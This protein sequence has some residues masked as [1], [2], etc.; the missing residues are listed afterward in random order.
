MSD[1]LAA[2]APAYT[3]CAYCPK[4]CR[5]ACP[6]AEAAPTES[7]STWGKMTASHLVETGQRPFDEDSARAVHACTGCM[8]CKSFCKHENQV[9]PALFAARGVTIE[10][11]LQPRGA[12]STLATFTQAQNPFGRELATLVASRRATGPV[13][14]PLFPGC[15]A[16]VKAEALIDDVLDVSRRFGAPMGVAKISSRCCGYPLFAAGAHDAFREHAVAMADALGNT[17]ELTVLDPGCA[18]TFL[19]VYPEFGVRLKTRVHTVVEVLADHLAHAPARAPLDEVVGYHDACLL[20]RGLGQFDQ[21]RALLHRAVRQV[22]E[23]AST[24]REGG[25]AGG[26]GLLPRTMPDVAVEVARRQAADVAP[27]PDFAVVTACPTSRRM[28]ER[29]G[30]KSY[31]LVSLLKRW[32]EGT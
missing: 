19:R 3:T 21:P 22:T 11:G 6:V 12:A 23:G 1:A 2:H 7:L 25:C 29:A 5:F 15:S 8:R 9:G 30:R 14:F 28:F 16:L 20:G 27:S 24:R 26:G 17:P 13:K 18:F 31:D 10:A 32:M 4:M